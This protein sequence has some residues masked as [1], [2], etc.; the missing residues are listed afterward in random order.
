MYPAAAS[1]ATG[2]RDPQQFFGHNAHKVVLALVTAVA[3][4]RND[5]FIAELK[6]DGAEVRFQCAGVIGAQD[7][8][9]SFGKAAENIDE[10]RI[11]KAANLQRTR[12]QFE[13]FSRRCEEM[14]SSFSAWKKS[15]VYSRSGR[16]WHA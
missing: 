16:V 7:V 10:L 12:E 8:L 6:D 15:L 2:Q 13:V 14:P 1:P 5:P 3:V 4:F 9:H 11:R